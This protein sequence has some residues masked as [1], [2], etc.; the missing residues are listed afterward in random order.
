ML[1]YNR[2]PD[3]RK[4]LSSLEDPC[5]F[6]FTVCSS[7]YLAD[8][9]NLRLVL[10]LVYPFFIIKSLA[11][12]PSPQPKLLTAPKSLKSRL[13]GLF[14]TKYAEVFE[15]QAQALILGMPG[16]CILFIRIST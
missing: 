6:V 14:F 10:L 4:L 1:L 16:G 11:Q 2:F 5:L 15:A 8:G 7:H 12:F 3:Q 13:C 9:N